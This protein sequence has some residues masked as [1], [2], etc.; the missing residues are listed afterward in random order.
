MHDWT[1]QHV[2][3]TFSRDGRDALPTPCGSG[4]SPQAAKATSKR[5]PDGRNTTQRRWGSGVGQCGRERRVLAGADQVED[6]SAQSTAPPVE[7]RTTRLLA[8]RGVQGNELRVT[9]REPALQ[10]PGVHAERSRDLVGGSGSRP[11]DHTVERLLG[12]LPERGPL[13]L[14]T[15]S[16]ACAQRGVPFRITA[17]NGAA[18][19][20]QR[21]L[22]CLGRDPGAS[23]AT[24]ALARRRQRSQVQP[25]TPFGSG[26]GSEGDCREGL[27]SGTIRP[28]LPSRS[29]PPGERGCPG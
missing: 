24:D 23:S 8:S 3:G 19:Q 29:C 17:L 16:T 25:R 26:R 20:A 21:T 2:V 13:R 9:L 12:P 6:R 14:T 27:P 11:G 10:G 18:G 4:A 1:N 22:G 5:R 15:C 28:R 7:Q